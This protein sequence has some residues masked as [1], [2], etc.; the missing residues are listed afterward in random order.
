MKVARHQSLSSLRY[1]GAG[2]RAN[3]ARMTAHGPAIRK[4]PHMP[5][6]D[7]A[8]DRFISELSRV[9]LASDAFNEY[10]PGDANNAIRRANLLLYLR[11]MAARGPTTLLVMEAP[12]YRGCRLTGVPVTSRKLLLEGVPALN[13][14]GAEAG[15]C[16]VTDAGFERVYG[17]QSATIVWATLAKLNALPFI[18]NTFPFHPH[19]AGQALSNRKPRKAET[20]LG[21]AILRCLLQ[22]W[23]F[24]RVIAVGNV[25]YETLNA[26]GFECVKVRHPAQGGKHDFVAGMTALFSVGA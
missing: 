4:T 3:Y 24:E 14:F 26:E 19:R 8:I 22:M 17:E 7:Q 20:V 5:A 1:N 10:A 13:M 9:T 18:W 15:Y 12:G 11:T 6:D 2:K 16:D 23:R 21:A 25:A